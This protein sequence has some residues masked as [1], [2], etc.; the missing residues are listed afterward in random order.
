MGRP[1]VHCCS[2]SAPLCSCRFTESAVIIPYNATVGRSG[3]VLITFKSPSSVP[4]YRIENRTKAVS[5]MLRQQLDQPSAPRGP[6]GGTSVSRSHVDSPV[7]YAAA[8]VAAAAAGVKAG[9]AVRAGVAAP[10]RTGRP[11]SPRWVVRSIF[12]VAHVCCQG[13]YAP[14]QPTSPC[15]FTAVDK[16]SP[17]VM[18][19]ICLLAASQWWVD[20]DTR[21]AL[22]VFKRHQG[23][24]R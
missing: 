23:L 2:S 5:L 15:T 20:L 3:T 14:I 11:E 18:P 8:T 19:L 17:G 1:L 4:P 10:P 7:S 24:C 22:S 13:E 6:P 16:N 12:A 9:A 21:C